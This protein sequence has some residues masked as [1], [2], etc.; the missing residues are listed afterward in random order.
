LIFQKTARQIIWRAIF[1]SRDHELRV[2][3]QV[4]LQR[5]P[6][7]IPLH[8]PTP[9]LPARRP[10][11]LALDAPTDIR[12]ETLPPGL[13]PPMT[14]PPPAEETRRPYTVNGTLLELQLPAWVANCTFQ[15]PSKAPALIRMAASA[16]VGAP[17]MAAR[18][19]AANIAGMACE[20]LKWAK[21]VIDWTDNVIFPA[22]LAVPL[23]ATAYSSKITV[24]WFIVA[25][26]VCLCHKATLHRPADQGLPWRCPC[27]LSHFGNNLAFSTL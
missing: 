1:F 8:R 6:R 23:M 25:N 10:L 20:G 11:P 16:G 13:M 2:A 12:T 5:S 21:I 9:E 3:C 18:T 17:A 24:P 19:A 15:T 4:P 22:L 7:M 14:L 27:W 26:S